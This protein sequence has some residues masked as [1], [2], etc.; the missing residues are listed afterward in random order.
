MYTYKKVLKIIRHICIIQY[1]VRINVQRLFI[2][3]IIVYKLFQETRVKKSVKV[4]GP[5]EKKTLRIK[6]CGPAWADTEGCKKDSQA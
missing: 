1:I 5:G 3:Y 2:V 4:K 6:V